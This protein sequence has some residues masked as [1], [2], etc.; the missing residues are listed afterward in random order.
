VAATNFV[1]PAVSATLVVLNATGSPAAT[2]AAF[3]FTVLAKV[4]RL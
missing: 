3:R 2:D 1:A 4:V